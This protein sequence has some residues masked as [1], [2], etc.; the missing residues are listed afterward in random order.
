MAV[1]TV[2]P[3]PAIE[4]R[5][6]TECSDLVTERQLVWLGSVVKRRVRPSGPKIAV[7]WE[8]AEQGSNMTLRQDGQAK[9][10]D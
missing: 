2:S 10:L 6:A 1:P 3:L 5:D 4:Q 7:C 8:T 9:N